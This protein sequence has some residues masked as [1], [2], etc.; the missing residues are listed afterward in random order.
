[1][2]ERGAGEVDAEGVTRL[3][4]QAGQ[5]LGTPHYM[6]PEQALGR[7]L[8]ARGW[9]AAFMPLYTPLRSK[10]GPRFGPEQ[11]SSPRFTLNWRRS[12]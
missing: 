2:S 12:D 5:V 3:Q 1:M 4:T 11:T 10:N 7:E 9:I 8:D 6:S